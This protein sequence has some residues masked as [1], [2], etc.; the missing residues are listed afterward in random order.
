MNTYCFYA[1]RGIWFHRARPTSRSSTIRSIDCLERHPAQPSGRSR[2]GARDN[3]PRGGMGMVRMTPF[4]LLL[5][6]LSCAAMMA[7]CMKGHGS[8]QPP[9][10]SMTN[11]L[12]NTGASV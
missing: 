11:D 5:Y 4:L 7:M 10:S 9:L 12:F 2:A 8:R 1:R 6:V 3:I